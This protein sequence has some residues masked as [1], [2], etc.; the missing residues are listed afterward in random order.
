MK[1]LYCI[2]LCVAI[3][4]IFYGCTSNPVF[5]LLP[6]K[7]SSSGS[8]TGTTTTTTSYY[9]GNINSH[10]F[11]KPTC[12]YLPAPANQITFSARADAIAAGYTPCGHCKP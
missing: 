12:S 2:L 4:A 1:Y 9:I 8:D 6:E 7:A 10:V 11:H 5:S 3:A